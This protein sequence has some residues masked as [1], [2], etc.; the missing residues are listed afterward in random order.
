MMSRNMLATLAGAALSAFATVA[1]A[2]TPAPAAAPA[3]EKNDY[4]KDAAWL[5]RPGKAND[6]CAI[7]LT[8]TVV[9]AD[10]STSVE[11][12]KADPGA[13]ID[14]FY[15][16]PTVS[17][18]PTAQSDMNAGPE[19]LNVVAQQFARFG[20]KCRL[21]APLYRQF[22]LAG[23]TSMMS[24]RPLPGSAGGL[25]SGYGDVRDAWNSYLEHDNK[26]RGVVL[27]GHSQGSMLLTPLIAS[28]I[29]GKPNQARLVSAILLGTSLPVEAGK[30]TGQFKSIPLCASAAQVG[31]VISYASFRDTLPPPAASLFGRVREPGMQSAC[32]NPANLAGGEG[33]LHAYLGNGSL[34]AGADSRA[35]TWAKDKTVKTPFVA[36][37]G[38]L[39]AQCVN[40]DGASYL[41][42]HVNA[43]PADP[44]ADDIPGDLIQGGQPSA[45]WGLHLVDVNLAMGNLLD[46]VGAQAKA[47]A[48]RK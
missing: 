17:R 32:V 29:D 15:V 33:G 45:G 12:F 1:V 30:T 16:Y 31:C 42:V 8:T 48:A 11:A 47:Y 40:K 14:C 43:D 13:P 39:T 36:V 25:A 2:Q 23:L 27:I 4:S 24:G 38:L 37:P 19:E 3:L 46:V 44:R 20:A 5:C 22:T 10:G 7:D 35:H 28:E 41:S 6:A 26:G 21:Y 34:I 9:K 18:D